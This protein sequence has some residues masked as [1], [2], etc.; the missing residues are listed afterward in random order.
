M[1]SA[2][3]SQ[4]AQPKPSYVCEWRLLETYRGDRHA[5]GK[6]SNTGG[7][8]AGPPIVRLDFASRKGIASDGRQFLLVGEPG[9]AADAEHF[10]SL[11]AV[12]DERLQTSKDVTAEFLS[13]QGTPGA[14]QS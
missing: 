14:E 2:I 3:T 7:Y 9:A 8:W 4:A 6:F 5:F 10:I 11:C 13:H 12:F 1:M